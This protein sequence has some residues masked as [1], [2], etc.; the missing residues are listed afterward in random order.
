MAGVMILFTNDREKMWTKKDRVSSDIVNS[1]KQFSWIFLS[2]KILSILKHRIIS[3][4]MLSRYLHNHKLKV[5]MINL[6]DHVKRKVET[7]NYEKSSI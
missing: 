5:P 4:V 2:K 3:M 7:N 1:I 6:W